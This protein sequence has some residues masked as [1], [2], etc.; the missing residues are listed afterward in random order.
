MPQDLK[1]N[2]RGPITKKSDGKIIPENEPVVIF[3][4][5]DAL[6]PEL[7]KYY[8]TLCQQHGCAAG[9]L[10]IIA[11]RIDEIQNWLRR[12]QLTRDDL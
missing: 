4:G 11:Q 9:H 5:Q 6:L 3:R 8:Y 10:E 7:L 1:Y 12:S 2:I